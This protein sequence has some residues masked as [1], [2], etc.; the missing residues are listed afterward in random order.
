MADTTNKS[1]KRII[2]DF[3]KAS[4]QVVSKVTNMADK[5]HSKFKSGTNS[6]VKLQV[7]FLRESVMLLRKT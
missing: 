5:M 4:K 6:I 1:L 7:A 3:D 2:V